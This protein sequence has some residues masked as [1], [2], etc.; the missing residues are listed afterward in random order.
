MCV[1]MCVP[2]YDTLSSVSTKDSTCPCMPSYCT[3]RGQ[4]PSL[5]GTIF[6]VLFIEASLSP[7]TKY[8]AL[9]HSVTLPWMTVWHGH[10]S[11]FLRIC[12]ME[13]QWKSGYHSMV[14]KATERKATSISS[15]HFRSAKSCISLTL[16]PVLPYEWVIFEGQ[17]F[18]VS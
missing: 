11:N 15:C 5:Q 4:L 3:K 16:Y 12:L 2:W 14:A 6:W 18:H 7:L 8:C 9:P 17:Y 10:I 1:C 13:K